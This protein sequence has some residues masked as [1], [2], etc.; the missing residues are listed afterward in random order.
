MA[1]PFMLV[2]FIFFGV[3]ANPQFTQRTEY[4]HSRDA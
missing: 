4:F 3:D 1:G 2:V